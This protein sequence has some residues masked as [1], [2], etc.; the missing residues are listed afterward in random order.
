MGPAA[1]ASP[2]GKAALARLDA[3]IAAVASSPDINGALLLEHLQSARTYLLGAM[4]EEYEFSLITVRQTAVELADPDLQKVVKKEV[5]SLLEGLSAARTSLTIVPPRHNYPQTEQ[6]N[7]KTELYR[8]FHGSATTLGVFY[9]THYIFASFPSLQN[10][11]DAAKALEASGYRELV[12]ASAAET[13]RFMSELR[14]DVGLWGALMAIISRFFGT[15]EVFADIDLEKADQGAGFLAVYC[16]REERAE[17]IRD[18]VAPFEPL[19]MQLYLS[20]GIQSL[21]AGRFPGPQ[22]HHSEQ[23]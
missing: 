13:F 8:F 18:I 1:I 15:E 11:K 22:G 14:A 10:A 7:D 6:D 3:L 4:P 23:S 2:I 12:T 19:A 17:Q 9:P 21:I 5:A 16:P 20:S